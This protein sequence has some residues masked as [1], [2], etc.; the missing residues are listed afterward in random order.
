MNDDQAVNDKLLQAVEA[1]YNILS[2]DPDYDVDSRPLID[3]LNE[4]DR[5]V[6]GV[7]IDSR[8]QRQVKVVTAET[9]RAWTRLFGRVNFVGYFAVPVNRE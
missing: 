5:V 7:W 4:H 6:A 3:H 9:S 1:T 2:G 8:G